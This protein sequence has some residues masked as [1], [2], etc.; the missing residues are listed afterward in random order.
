MS[1]NLSFREMLLSLMQ[2][3]LLM[4]NSCLKMILVQWGSF[5]NDKAMTEGYV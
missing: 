4:V 5:Y 1:S 2:I 3:W